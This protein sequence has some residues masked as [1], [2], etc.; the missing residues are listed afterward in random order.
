M[1]LARPSADDS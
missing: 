1:A